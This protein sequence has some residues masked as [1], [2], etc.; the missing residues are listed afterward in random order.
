MMSEISRFLKGRFHDG[1]IRDVT[2]QYV[3]KRSEGAK[4]LS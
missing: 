1:E 3:S 4:H 2:N